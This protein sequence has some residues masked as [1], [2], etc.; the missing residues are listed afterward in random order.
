ML[1]PDKIYW[2]VLLMLENF[3]LIHPTL[4]IFFTFNTLFSRHL[5]DVLIVTLV[6]G[7][8]PKEV[9]LLLFNQQ[10]IQQK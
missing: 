1:P 8:Y 4:E 3:I 9:K 2:M 6:T 5:E 10:V 7:L